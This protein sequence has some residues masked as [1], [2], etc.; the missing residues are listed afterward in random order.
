MEI[1]LLG[2]YSF[3]VWL[4]FF[5]LKWLPW[6]ITSQVIVVTLPVI[7]ITALILFLNIFAPSSHDVRVI[8]YV[9]QI[10]PRVAGRVIEVP[11][12]PDKPVKKGDVLFRIDPTPYESQ[13]K[14]LEAQ[15][16]EL[17]AG[18]ASAE[19]YQR[20][21][22]QQLQTARSKKNSVSAKLEL[23]RKRVEQT[24]E[25]ADSGA[26]PRFDYEQAVTDLDTLNGEIAAA[27]ATEAEVS[28]K[29][30]ARTDEGEL[31]DVA[32]AKAELARVEAQ[33][34]EARWRLDETT[35]YAPTDGTVVNLQLRVGSAV[36]AF[37]IAP[38]M[39]FVENEQWLLALF[40]QN[41]L[42][43][44][45]SGNEAE[46]ALLTYPNRVIKCKVD[47][48]IWATGSGQLPISGVIPNQLT[49]P[50]PPGYYAVR[51][52]PEA[53]DKDLFLAA[54]AAGA[55]AI[56][57]EHGHMIHIIRKVIVRVGTKLDWLVLKLH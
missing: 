38:A 16:P 17:R 53:K 23:A 47:S 56:Y 34:I 44:V 52:L 13:A 40:R 46:V 49:Q 18:I 48:I 51:L 39:S 2:I 33:L 37:P 45:E 26:G 55:G 14:A 5:K 54:G 12:E 11:V 29:L 30:S 20:Q 42:R 8:N 27:T 57:T 1:I 15:I 43:Y 6:N 9:V 24:K 50:V 19:A 22:G 36:T 21:L 3:F 31:A 4:I 32:K 10:V 35:V 25:L 41:E 7:G 28:Q